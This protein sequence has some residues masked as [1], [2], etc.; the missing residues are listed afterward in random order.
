MIT[1]TA[2]PIRPGSRAA[3]RAEHTKFWS[4]RS[5]PVLV[6]MALVAAAVLALLF[7]VSLPVTQGTAIAEMA[8]AR[9]V[10]AALVG[11]DVAAIVLIVLGA[12]FMGSEYSSGL[13]QPTFLL[14]PRRGRVLLAKAV[15]TMGVTGGVA[16]AAAAACMLVGQ[17]V[18]LGS[19]LPGAD[20]GDPDLLRLAAGSALSPIFYALVAL[21][22][23]TLTRSTG[24]G[25]VV[26]LV[27]L[28]LPTLL[29]WIPGPL[30]AIAVPLLPAAAL[31][32]IS[33]AAAPVEQLPVGVAAVLL[34]A[35]TAVGLGAAVLRLRSCDA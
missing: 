27:L 33:G 10:E 5:L 4:V 6:L 24:G 19:G 11:L 28:V 8:P 17:A 18:L 32:S 23:A 22:G 26:A 12:S 34:L 7:C 21:V 3:L 35:W 2:P 1:T 9:V 13:A 20:L 14:T 25:L 15:V 30:A 31:H 29:G 16:V